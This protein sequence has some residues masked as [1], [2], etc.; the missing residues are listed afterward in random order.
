[1]AKKFKRNDFDVLTPNKGGGGR[2]GGT[3]PPPGVKPKGV[4]QFPGS[5]DDGENGKGDPTN[6]APPES[7]S[8]DK[9][10]K[11]KKDGGTGKEKGD[12][13][14]TKPDS[15]GGTP[16]ARSTKLGDDDGAVSKSGNN[17]GGI[18]DSDTSKSIQ[19]AEGVP[20][21]LPNEKTW[22][23]WGDTATKN[24]DRLTS[25]R[26]TIGGHGGGNLRK[27]IAELYT[28]KVDWRAELK[29]F[30]GKML[31]QTEEYMGAR[32]HIHS[33]M[34]L[35]G[36]RNLYEGL[37]QA[38]VAV[39]VSG[40]VQ[41]DFPE[42][43]TEVA[44]IS[45]ARQI[46]KIHVTPFADKV[47]DVVVLKKKEPITP[48]TFAHVRLGGGTEAIGDVIQYVKDKVKNNPAFVVI[49]TDGYLTSGL[50]KAP[51]WGKKTIWLIFSQDDKR[52]INREFKAPAEW[53]R[54]IYVTFS[55]DG[56]W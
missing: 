31:S 45:K 26:G 16:K 50:P 6:Y 41:G 25:E 51:V 30:I 39:D 48:E 37:D 18:M 14:K 15:G 38:V 53:G 7:D 54:V 29:R 46:Q 52:S 8:K 47:K 34:Y 11:D 35:T 17:V 20:V 13:L 4:Q 40:S 28:P 24:I 55:G 33:G 44:E 21:E 3:P 2:P 56:K 42:F 10:D 19:E 43:I 22:E 49:I 36:E 1:M 32:R 9:K 27:K 5:D 23:D 12:E